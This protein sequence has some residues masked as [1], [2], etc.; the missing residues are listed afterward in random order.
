MK[1]PLSERDATMG[2]ALAS[3]M[4]LLM[5]AGLWFLQSKESAVAD[6][7]F[8]VADE[9]QDLGQKAER[10]QQP[11]AKVKH[12]IELVAKRDA[13]RQSFSRET[14]Y[15]KEVMAD[16]DRAAVAFVLSYVLLILVA[17]KMAREERR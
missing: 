1:T 4:L 9:I 3:A 10:L 5:C 7:L 13:L 16:I 12:V 17:V 11:G 15:I 8:A 6:R 2:Y 14:A